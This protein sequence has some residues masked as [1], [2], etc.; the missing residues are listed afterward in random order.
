MSPQIETATTSRPDVPARSPAMTV[1]GN[2]LSI[3]DSE[4]VHVE[5]ELDAAGKVVRTR[6]RHA[7]ARVLH[8]REQ[9]ASLASQKLPPQGYSTLRGLAVLLGRG[10]DLRGFE[11][12]VAQ[13]ESGGVEY[14]T[15]CELPVPGGHGSLCC[16]EH[17]VWG[18]GAERLWAG[19]LSARGYHAVVRRWRVEHGVITLIH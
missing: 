18:R 10:S 16:P 9:L 6:E 5:A 12:D 2:L 11:H 1:G 4:L 14:V 7:V 13:L 15:L 17:R 8:A 3:F 19:I